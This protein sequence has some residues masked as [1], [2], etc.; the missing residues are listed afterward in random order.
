MVSY[1]CGWLAE[2]SDFGGFCCSCSLP[3]LL[4]LLLLLLLYAG[5]RWRGTA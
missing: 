5:Q 4:L 2:H 3:L 1:Q